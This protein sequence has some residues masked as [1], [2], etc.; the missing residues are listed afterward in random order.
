MLYRFKIK[1]KPHKN[2]KILFTS[3][4]FEAD[5]LT[6]A[7]NRKDDYIQN[8]PEYN[9]CYTVMECK[10]NKDGKRRKFA[11]MAV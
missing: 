2:S 11:G 6:D 10:S 4:W 7:I 9:R 1:L 3:A 5:C 8:K